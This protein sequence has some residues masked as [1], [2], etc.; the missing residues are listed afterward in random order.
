MLDEQGNGG[1]EQPCEENNRLKR[2]ELRIGSC[3]GK[4]YTRI[5]I[6]LAI[7]QGVF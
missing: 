3:Y 6:V 1:G 2:V 4:L 5:I 7:A